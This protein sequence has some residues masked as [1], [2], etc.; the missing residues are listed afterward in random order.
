MVFNKIS[1]VLEFSMV[2]PRTFNLFD[3]ILNI[4]F[5]ACVNKEAES[6]LQSTSKMPM[7]FHVLVEI[8]FITQLSTHNLL[9][10]EITSLKTFSQ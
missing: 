7:A 8:S 3:D 2:F 6:L 10:E 1:T 4:I 5:I 9:T